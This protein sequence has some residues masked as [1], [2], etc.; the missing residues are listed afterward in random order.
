MA[1]DDGGR[2]V[3]E[4]GVMRHSNSGGGPPHSKTLRESEAARGFAT[5]NLLGSVFRA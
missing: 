4:I 5:P 1:F 3:V 2:V